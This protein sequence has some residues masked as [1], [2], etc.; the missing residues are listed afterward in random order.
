MF[1]YFINTSFRNFKK[2]NRNFL[3]NSIG[4]S[5]AFTS[6]ILVILWVND[7]YSIDKFHKNE[8]QIFQVLQ[9]FKNGN[10]IFTSEWTPAPLA[11]EIKDKIANTTYATNVY[12]FGS[13]GIVSRKDNSSIRTNEIF[14]GQDFFNMFSFNLIQGE[15]NDVLQNPNNVVLSEKLAKRIFNSVENSIGK[16]IE[17]DQQEVSGLYIVTGVFEEVPENSTLKF[18]AVFSFSHLM[19]K[20]PAINSWESNEPF[21]YVS[22]NQNSNLNNFN[23]QLTALIKEKSK[24]DNLNSV[25]VRKFSDKYLYN[26]YENGVQS[27]GRINYIKLFVLIA[28]FILIIAAI[29]FTNLSTSQ[30]INRVKEIGVKKVLGIEKKGL[31]IQ[32]IG[33]SVL[34][35]FLALILAFIIV[36]II[37]PYFNLVVNKNINLQFSLEMFLLII[38][39]TCMTGI[40]SGIYPSIY[41]SN[42]KTTTLLKGKITTKGNEKRIRQG[43]V[44]FQFTV[45]IFLIISVVIITNQINLIQNK[46]LGYNKDQVLVLKKDGKLKSNTETFLKE[47]RNISGVTGASSAVLNHLTDNSTN[48]RNVIWNGKEPSNNTPFKYI[49]ANYDFIELLEIKLKE[50]RS[51]SKN[52]SNE[53][54]KIIVNETAINEMGLK[55][56][57]GKSIKIWGSDVQIIGVVNDF[58]FQSLYQKMNP[59]FMKISDKGDEIL[60][61]IKSG[62]ERETLAALE[63]FHKEFNFGLPFNFRFL[64]SDYQTFYEAE[65]RVVK[66]FRY[67]GS[68]AIIISC[69]GLFGLVTFNIRQRYKEIGVR[70]VLGASVSNIIMLISK[71]FLKL[72]FISILI[73]I[74]IAWIVLNNWLQNF[75]YRIEI[76]WFVFAAAGCISIIVALATV[77]FQTIKAAIANPTNSLKTE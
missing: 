19:E 51:F 36:I 11:K 54:Q 27:G 71:D 33:E 14:A 34:T 62:T 49:L 47:V 69:M 25:F 70:K 18:N 4:L 21:T 41:L 44:I 23:S 39:T 35:S 1:R 32:F 42:F 2:F 68:I 31:I 30:A 67:F 52:Y 5:A 75:A 40:I 63:N 12:S 43:L 24:S 48:T 22:V 55:N 9:N 29:N 28:F 72:I 3:I 26:T 50:G 60:V 64:D 10:D 59:L 17:F 53:K 45:S 66:L 20:L 77:S 73:A 65:N 56:P 74:P 57:I 46:E 8:E 38:G 13:K 15:R 61:K 16:T 6:I 58:H 7:E 37:L 76:H